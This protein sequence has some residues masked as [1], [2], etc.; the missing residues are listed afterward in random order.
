M[1]KIFELFSY[2]VADHSKAAN[3]ARKTAHC[4]FMGRECDGG[5][6]RHLSNLNIV[7][8]ME[9]RRFFTVPANREEVASG[10]C[11]IKLQ[12]DE[13][14]WIVCPRRLMALSRT[15]PNGETTYQA[16]TE[17]RLLRLFGYPSGT[18]IGIWS[19]VK[20]GYDEKVSGEKKKFDYAFDYILS[21]LGRVSQGEAEKATGEPWAQISR[22]LVAHGF[23]IAVRRGESFVEDFPVGIPSIIEIMTCSTS[24]SDKNKRSTIPNAVEDALLKNDHTAPGINFRQVWARMVSQLIV[25]SE[26]A[27]HWGGKAVWIVQDVLV[28]Y[29]CSSTALDIRRFLAERTNEVNMLSLAYGDRANETKGVIELSFSGLYA[30]PIAPTAAA[31]TRPSFS[32]MVR[33]PLKPALPRLTKLLINKRP[34]NKIT[35]P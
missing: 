11:S 21:P 1:P 30:G 23:T 29:I 9:L 20:L 2:P 6:N 4:S 32:D 5:G 35:V 31:G 17:A 28:D 16:T 12:P 18:R 34:V 19:E 7:R 25:K 8:N 13:R 15:A 3:K 26:V 22:A 27:L 33:T 10:V 14:P 24:G